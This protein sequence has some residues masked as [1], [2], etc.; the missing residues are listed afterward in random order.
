[1]IQHKIFKL[2]FKYTVYEQHY[3]LWHTHT[4][5]FYTIQLPRIQTINIW[6]SCRWNTLT[7][8][9]L[10][11]SLSA[12]LSLAWTHKSVRCDASRENALLKNS[13][14]AK[15]SDP[16]VMYI[17]NRGIN[18]LMTAI[19]STQAKNVMVQFAFEQRSQE[20]K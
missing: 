6:G 14:E 17:I 2:F 12:S 19:E 1:M 11:V 5:F 9:F 10:V 20:G 7:C 3:C 16:C 4:D 8:Y 15:N 13:Y 18:P